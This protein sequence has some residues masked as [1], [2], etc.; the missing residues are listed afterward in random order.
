M[1]AVVQ[2][3]FARPD[4]RSAAQAFTRLFPTEIAA[5]DPIR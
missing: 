2:G 5:D 3:V 1:L 4:I